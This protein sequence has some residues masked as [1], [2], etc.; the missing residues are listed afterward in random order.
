MICYEHNKYTTIIASNFYILSTVFI[1]SMPGY[2]CTIKERM[3]Y[4]SC[5]GPL[6]DLIQSLGVT[7]A[8]KVS[9]I[10]FFLINYINC[11]ASIL[12]I[13]LY[14]NVFLYRH[15]LFKFKNKFNTTI[16]MYIHTFNF[17]IVSF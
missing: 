8:K 10:N 14:I 1:Y 6:L 9:R 7:I 5:K 2:S 11:F 4:S 15:Y 3:L 13:L 16:P 12:S 17:Y